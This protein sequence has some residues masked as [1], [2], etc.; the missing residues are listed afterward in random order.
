MDAI[1]GVAIA[2]RLQRLPDDPLRQHFRHS[3]IKMD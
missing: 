2:D 1:V 3:A